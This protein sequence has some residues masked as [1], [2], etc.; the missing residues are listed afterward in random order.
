ML[1]PISV[2]FFPI[3]GFLSVTMD[4]RSSATRNQVVTGTFGGKNECRHC[5]V[6]FSPSM[7]CID[8]VTMT[9]DVRSA[10]MFVC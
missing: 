4:S 3:E 8:P 7:F 9:L 5:H 2:C 6:I 1:G 10:C